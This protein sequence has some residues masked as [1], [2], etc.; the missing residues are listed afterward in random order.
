MIRGTCDRT[1]LL[2]LVENYTL[3]MEMRGG[4]IKLVAKN[5]QYL[6][7]GNTLDALKDIKNRE[8]RL[9]VFWHTQGSGK[10]VSMIF[11]AQQVLRKMPGN[12]TFVIVTDCSCDYGVAGDELGNQMNR[13][14]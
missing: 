3:F 11:F 5:H 7:V 2:D 9:G 13:S 6:G 12:W 14:C 10:S 8:G 4:T 1:R